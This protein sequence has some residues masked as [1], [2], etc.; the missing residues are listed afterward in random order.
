MDKKVGNKKRILLFSIFKHIFLLGICFL[1]V[2][3]VLYALFGAFKTN[4]DL[5]LGGRLL[6][7]E[8]I[9]SNFYVALQQLDFLHFFVNSIFLAV[10]TT[11][12]SLLICSLTGFCL[13]RKEFPGRK[14][15]A[16]TILA[17]MFISIGTVTLRPIFVMMVGLNMHHTLI[18]VVLI[19][20]SANMGTFIFL[21]EKFIRTVPKE[22]DEAA[23]IDGASTFRIYWQV[24]LP[25]ILPIL[26]VV[27]LFSFRLAW[28][29]FINTTVFTMSAPNLRTLTVGVVAL[30]HGMDSAAQW[31]IMLAGASLSIV[32]MLIV[33][34]LTNKT[35][36]SGLAAGGVKG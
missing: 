4:M 35:F 34:L 26:G 24:I 12:L 9:F 36:I 19:I 23:Y 10:S 29:D 31:N 16:N 6:P 13:A 20:V 28:N 7:E 21:I 17:T 3:P 30:R 32:P 22:L 2:Y 18:P 33:Y 25:L 1:L 15:L 11:I 27:G 5:T 8:W 14:I